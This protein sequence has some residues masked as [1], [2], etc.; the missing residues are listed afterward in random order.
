MEALLHLLRYLRDN[1][2]LGLKFYLDIL[3]SPITRL[4]SNNGIPL[5]NPLCTFTDSSWID[6]IDTGW[7][8]GYF[9]ILFCGFVKC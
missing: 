9:M 8:S 5:D 7:S 3:M 1:I 4:L 6:D 2:Y